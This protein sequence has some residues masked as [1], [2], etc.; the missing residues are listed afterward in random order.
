M[1]DEVEVRKDAVLVAMS[2]GVG[3]FLSANGRQTLLGDYLAEQWSTP[4]NMSTFINDVSFDL[5]SA[6]D[7]RTVIAVWQRTK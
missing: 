5:K 6:D 3:N 7:D 4:V 2:D 1:I